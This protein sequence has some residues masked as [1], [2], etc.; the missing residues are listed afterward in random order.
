MGICPIL[1]STHTGAENYV[2]DASREEAATWVKIITRLPPYKI[3]STEMLP[4]SHESV[5]EAC[6]R[7]LVAGLALQDFK[8]GME[9]P[10]VIS[11]IRRYVQATK[12]YP[13]RGHPSLQ[14]MQLFATKVAFGGGTYKNVHHIVGRHFGSLVEEDSR[15]L[16]ADDAKT[17]NARMSFV[18][19]EL[20]PLPLVSWDDSCL[21][22]QGSRGSRSSGQCFPLSEK[23]KPITVMRA[24]DTSKTMFEPWIIAR[25]SN[26]NSSDGDLLEVLAH[27]SLTMASLKTDCFS[28]TFL[29]GVPLLTALCYVSKLMNMKVASFDGGVPVPDVLENLDYDWF[30]LPALA[31]SNSRLSKKLNA[32]AGTN[33]G[34]LDR[35]RNKEGMMA[36][37]GRQTPKEKKMASMSWL[38]A[39]IGKVV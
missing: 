18:D 10:R 30:T 13:W 9:L 12:S 29:G 39:R 16:T 36:S 5:F 20:E 1:M 2:Q 3:K 34:F 23:G 15:S 38:S 37:Y 17:F 19:G 35:P 4:A 28:S 24:F 8:K 27:A 26:V 7:P 11:G 25:N 22:S 6:E 14:L 21:G 31:G 32:L 33:I